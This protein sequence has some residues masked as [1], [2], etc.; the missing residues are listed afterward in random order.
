[1]IDRVAEQ[2]ERLRQA[3]AG[4]SLSNEAAFRKSLEKFQGGISDHSPM[5]VDVSTDAERQF[6]LDMENI[7]SLE[8]ETHS[9]EVRRLAVAMRR[10]L[11]F[12]ARTK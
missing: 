6:A 5:V 3:Q 9:S 2:R 7:A 4:G 11:E 12:L 8:R 1:M 10:S